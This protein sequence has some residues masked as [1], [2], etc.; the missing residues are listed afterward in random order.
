MAVPRR[1]R[2]T[3]PRPPRFS[4]QQRY[5]NDDEG[6]FI[7]SL[8]DT[9]HLQ[10]FGKKVTATAG[11]LI[12]AEGV[13]QHYQNAIGELHRELRRPLMQRS[14]FSFAQTTPREIVRSRISVPEIQQRALAYIPND[15]LANIP[16]D[17]S[18]FSL[19]QGFEASLPENMGHRLE[20]MG[21]R[22]HMCVAEIHEIDNKIANLN[23]MRKMVLDRLAGL[24]IE[25]GELEQDLLT[26]DNQIEDLQ[27]E[28]DDEAALAPK[29]ANSQTSEE[30]SEGKGEFMSESIYQK[31]PSSPRTKSKAKRLSK[32]MSM[33]VLHEHLQSGSKIKEL[34]GH[35]DAITAMDFDAPW[36]M[37]VT[38][39]LDDT[40]RVWDLSA[41]RCIGML[42]GHLSSVRCLQVEENIVAT[43]SMDASIRL[44]DLSKAEYAPHDNR[45]NKQEEESDDG[46]AFENSEDAPPAPPST[47]MRDC[48]MFSLESHVDEVTALHFRGDTLVSGSADKTLRQWDLVKGR[49]VQ[50]LDVLWAAA[51]ATASNN[52]NTT[53]RQTGR[54]SDTSADF[55][56]AIQ[57]FDAA[58]A[59]GT[60]DGMVRLWDLRSGQVHRSLV[61]HT[62]PVTALQFDD[63]H[64]VTGSADRSIRIWDL[65]TGAIADAYAYDHPVTSM[66]FDTRRIVSAAGVDVVKV[67]DKMDGRHWD[68]GP[69]ADKEDTSTH[70]IIEHVRIKDGYLVEGRR[71]GTQSPTSTAIRAASTKPIPQP[72][73][74]LVRAAYRTAAILGSFVA[75][76]GVLVVAFFIYDAYTYN[77]DPI[78]TDIPVSEL[79]LSPRRG[80]PKNLPI[81]EHFV[82]DD[83]TPEN[84]KL[85]HKPKLVILGTGWGSVA[86]LKQLNE[87]DYHVTVISPSNTFLFTPMLP[88]ATVGTLELR[89]LVE[90]VRRIVRR[91][92]GHFLKAKAEDV[93]F[94][95][96]LIECS[97]VDAQGKEQRFYVP[98]DKLVVGVGSVTNSHGVKGLEHCH[99]LKDISDARII[100]NQVVRNLETACLPTTSD[101]ERRRLLSFVVCGGG[102]TGVEFAA[103]LFDMLNEDLCK[104]YPRLLRNEISV[105]VI[106]SRSHILNTYEEALSQYAEQRFAHDSVDIL[107][108][109]R[110]K[111]VQADKILFSQKDSDGKVITK[112]IPMGFCL[113]STGVA[114]TDFCKRLAAKL[115]GQNNRHALET[116]T[117]LRLNGSPLGDVY[118]IGDCA[119][120]QNN[121]SDHIVNFLRTT[122]WEKGKDPESLQISYQDWRGIAKR[123]KQR[124]PQAA[125][126]L[127]RLDKLFEQYDKDKSGTLDFGELRELLFQIDSKLTS[128]PATAQRAN[129]QGE[130]LG[131][132]FNKIAQ[133]APGLA[134]NN[135]DY[136]DL[137]DA[138]YKAFEY[139]HLG[140]LAYIGNAAIFDYNGYGLSEC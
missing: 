107:T 84:K 37:M 58:L 100:R 64:L 38:A 69:G 13:S 44:W 140:S 61:G 113:W 24:E 132:K 19:F 131:R 20:M 92:H 96:K 133:A 12:G 1:G 139:K 49:C 119:T 130:Y 73:S 95:K 114:Q 4:Q 103:E 87:D 18:E 136:G 76:S 123:V 129:Q 55:V 48:P 35:L 14:V 42:E 70:S 30:Q 5:D 108:N 56:G 21:V 50:T 16:E 41:G 43:G 2:S 9:R 22:K 7:D 97:A 101:E 81:A 109:S 85:K 126:H 135:V 8:P 125:N 63:V 23:T 59:C 82:D 115:D 62:G 47:S 105:H 106:Q 66:M 124:F 83:E 118:A 90:P 52:T 112:E 120:V 60:A 71:N 78:A 94:S 102:P 104:M 138:V 74:R 121:V 127:R 91:V 88:S 89:S 134:M 6:S 45:I 80:G 68:C 28:L 79:A 10:A 11:S 110:V 36:G 72:R 122:A 27:E 98:Y 67:Y 39:A 33:P 34:P 99:F 53:W 111:E 26:V 3:S 77:D 15:L 116:D 137:D 128:L 31:I 93:E 75:V 117:H 32:R 29:T 57:V 86:L 25:E 54:S 51:Q 46:L 65:R 40:V 17:N